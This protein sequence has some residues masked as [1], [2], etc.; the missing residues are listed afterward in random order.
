MFVPEHT[1][2]HVHIFWDSLDFNKLKRSKHTPTY[3]LLQP[4]DIPMSRT[5]TVICPNKAEEQKD[6]SKIYKDLY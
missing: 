3:K 2:E 4:L 6:F 1:L 5:I